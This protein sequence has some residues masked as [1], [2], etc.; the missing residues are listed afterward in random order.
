MSEKKFHN[1][2]IHNT[3]LFE[4]DNFLVIP[5]IGSIVEGWLLIIPKEQYISM[6]ALNNIVFAELEQL[7]EK[8]GEMVFKRYGNYVV[9]EN[10]AYSKNKLVGCGV[11]YAHVHIVPT[12]LNLMKEIETKFDIHYQWDSIDSIR[13]SKTYIENQMP[14]LYYRNQAKESFITTSNDIPSQ[15]FRKT[16]AISRGIGEKYDWKEFPFI[17]N[18]VKTIDSFKLQNVY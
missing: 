8:I 17:E 13:I 10:G 7:I 2:E 9:F 1:K 14:Y 11:D 18:V 6:G 15:L 16:I 5:S 12:D 3:V 4:S